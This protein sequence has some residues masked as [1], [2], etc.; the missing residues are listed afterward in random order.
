MYWCTKYG[1]QHDTNSFALRSSWG[2][3]EDAKM[4]FA[5]FNCHVFMDRLRAPSLHNISKKK[6]GVANRLTGVYISTSCNS[7]DDNTCSS[8]GH[9]YS[10]K[11]YIPF[12]MNNFCIRTSRFVK[13]NVC[14]LTELKKEIVHRLLYNKLRISGGRVVKLLA[15]GARGPGFDSRPRHFNFQKL[16][17]SCFQVEIWLIFKIAKAK[18][19]YRR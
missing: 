11:F 16:V 19:K 12:T 8:S 9:I 18:E 15:C 4:V 5:E 7:N 6:T 1:L 3:H 14:K 2:G 10:N 13:R 17:I